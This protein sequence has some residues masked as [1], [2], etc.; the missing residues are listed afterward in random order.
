M[1]I[2]QGL[3]IAGLCGALVLGAGLGGARLGANEGPVVLVTQ[4]WVE[5]AIAQAIEE[6]IAQLDLGG[7]VAEVAVFEPVLVP[8]GYVLFG[9]TGTEVIARS[10]VVAANVP[11]ADG[12]V[13]VTLGIDMLHGMVIERNHYLIIPREDGRGV[14]AVTDAWMMV[15]G[16]FDIEAL[17]TLP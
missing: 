16:G 3:Y 7:T 8:A 5:Q 4:H 6:V 9:H 15:K 1:K 10:G 14:L 2:R 17:P 12:L 11:G 13:N